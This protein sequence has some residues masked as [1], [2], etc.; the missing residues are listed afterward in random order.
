M[1]ATMRRW[2]AGGIRFRHLRTRLTVLYAGLFVI[3]L[4]VIAG[5]AQLMIQ[6]HARESVRAELTASGAVYDR[7]WALKASSL[8]DS[9]SVMARDFGFR[10]A[11]ASGDRS[12]IESALASLRA[13][14]GVRDAFVVDQAG[15]VLGNGPVVAACRPRACPLRACTRDVRTRWS[16]HAPEATGWWS[17]RS[18]RRPRS[19][20]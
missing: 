3:A 6:R 2:M 19:A 1:R 14:V 20:G 10:S 8:T 17:R 16:R 7:I 5:A 9:A 13:R 12:T 11:V 15:D 4:L 18:S